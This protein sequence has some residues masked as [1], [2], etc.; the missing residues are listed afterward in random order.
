MRD[1]H[2]LG[3]AYDLAT[4]LDRR[5]AL[6]LLAGA[7]LVALVGC[8]DDSPSASP[9]AA[10][11]GSSPATSCEEI[12][13]ETAGPFPGNGTN[14]PNV[15]TE[16]GVVREDITTSFGAMS[17]RA[18]GL[19]LAVDLLV[20]SRSCAALPGAA[21]Y[22]WQCDRDG[23]Y[24][25]YSEGATDRNYLRGVQVA[26]ANGRV[27]FASVFPGAYPGRWPHIHFEVYESLVAAQGGAR[28][29]ATSQLALPQDAC[30]A[31]YGTSGYEASARTLAGTSF[32]RD[33]VFADDGGARQLAAMSGTV[34]RGL[35]AAL[36]VPV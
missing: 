6:R 35:R 17:G 36:T 19:P 23:L 24:S 31:A 2:D 26:D 16:S 13:G 5:G 33:M 3:L 12:P 9:S 18:A 11:S 34:G 15:L 4:L 30:E 27:S 22:L 20:Q 21:V 1:D 32:A 29:V 10:P 8:S 14:G 25:L 28:P 7:G